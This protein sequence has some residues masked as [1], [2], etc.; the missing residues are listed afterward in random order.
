MICIKFTIKENN[1]NFWWTAA[2]VL[3]LLCKCKCFYLI[4]LV[5]QPS[6]I[7]CTR[8]PAA[9]LKWTREFVNFQTTDSGIITITKPFFYTNASFHHKILLTC[10]KIPFSIVNSLNFFHLSR[11]ALYIVLRRQYKN[12]T[13]NFDLVL[14]IICKKRSINGDFL[15]TLY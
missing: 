12:C 6:I 13:L 11:R 5:A 9:E 4:Q 3:S 2:L 7:K 8:A 10:M 14:L 15:H 1:N